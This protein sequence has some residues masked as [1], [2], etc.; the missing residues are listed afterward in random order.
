M[1]ILGNLITQICLVAGP[2]LG[3]GIWAHRSSYSGPAV[4]LLGMAAVALMLFILNQGRTLLGQ[5]MPRAAPLAVP[6]VPLTAMRNAWLSD[7][8]HC[9]VK[10]RP[11]FRGFILGPCCTEDDSNLRH[12]GT[13]IKI[14][15][16]EPAKQPD[17]S[18]T[19]E[20]WL[21]PPPL[22]NPEPLLSILPVP[23]STTEIRD[24]AE[25][26][27][28]GNDSGPWCEECGRF[29]KMGNRTVGECRLDVL[30]QVRAEYPVANVT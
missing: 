13:T 23:V 7:R 1:G 12:K 8:E 22:G 25:N 11:Q 24:L 29:R 5:R 30:E 10:W 20:G 2:T 21:R 18:R 9:G 19:P 6:A 15:A 27:R 26:D 17:S 16:P 3:V 14:Q 4:A 28:A